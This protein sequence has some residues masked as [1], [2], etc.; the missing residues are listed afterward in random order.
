[1]F[2]SLLKAIRSKNVDNVR[3]ALSEEVN[4]NEKDP[5]FSDRSPLHQ[6]IYFRCDQIILSLLI[7]A[8]ANVNAIDKLEYTPLHLAAMA[9]NDQVENYITLLIKFYA[10]VNVKDVNGDTPL[11]VGIKHQ[12][13]NDWYKFTNAAR[14][15]IDHGADVNTW[16]N[17]GT[18]PLHRAADKGYKE[19]INLLLERGAKVNKRDNYGDT[20]LHLA[21]ANGKIEKEI[22][23]LLL[24]AGANVELKNG[25]DET[26]LE[27]A[28]MN[29][30]KQMLESLLGVGVDCEN[31]TVAT[32]LTC[33]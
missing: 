26:P 15:L 17:I 29:G 10:N 6:A 19:I 20:P 4:V 32:D 30:N 3:N 9:K 24:D 22:I 21:V 12:R 1:M 8:G 16:S 13:P 31:N 11:Q 2:Q 7:D 18:T 27:V 5:S 33:K 23:K 28:A 14:I 25:D